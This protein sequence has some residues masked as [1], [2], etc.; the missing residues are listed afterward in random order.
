MFKFIGIISLLIVSV[1]AGAQSFIT[2]FE[3]SDSLESA[4]YFQAVSFYEKLDKQYKT[5][6]IEYDLGPTD[7]DYP[8]SVVYYDGDEPE[9]LSPAEWKKKGKTII[10]IN[11][12]I[13]PGEPDGIDACM[14]L[15]R[16]AATGKIN[17]PKNIVIAV[18]PVFN[19][20]GCLNRNSYSRANQNGPKEYGFRGNSQNLD[21]NRDFMKLDAEETRTLVRFMRWL[22]PDIFIDNHVSDGADYQHVMTLL[23]TQHNK[24]GGETGSYMNNTFVPMIYADMKKRGYDLVPYVN[25]F[26]STPDHGWREFY[27]PPRFGSGYVALWQT[28]AFVPE[29]HMLKPFR[30]RVSATYQLMLSFISTAALHADDIKTA[31]NN[32]REKLLQKKEFTLDWKVDTTRSTPVTFKGYEAE[33]RPSKVSGQPRLF[34]DHNKP[35]TKQ[36]PFYNYYVASK[37]ITAPKAYV[38]PQGWSDVIERLECNGVYMYRLR[39]DSTMTLT[40][41]RI[42]K[43]ETVPAPYEKHYLHRNINVTVQNEKVKLLKGDYIIPVNQPAKRYLIEALEPTAPDAFLAWNFFDG[44][45]QQKEYFSDYVFEDTAA[46][47]LQRDN[48]LKLLL[49][50]KSKADSSF[51]KNGAAQLDFIYRHSPY[52]EPSNMRYPVFRID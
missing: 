41:Y 30:Q 32:D 7:A 21:L 47:I 6:A 14:M 22:D 5:I 12:G 17:I 2:P 42:T 31:R 11:N 40:T 20:G 10:L 50:N 3:S 43:Y 1:L 16:D 8:L 52:Y 49:D 26:S 24:L 15:M 27:E 25:D 39:S 28:M 18:I 48:S 46:S 34:Y 29:T 19:I 13:H 23:A 4:T 51:Q 44:I 33:Y 35:F 36:V 45:L 38:I 9:I 37:K